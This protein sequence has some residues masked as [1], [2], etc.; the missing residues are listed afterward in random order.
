MIAEKRADSLSE[1]RAELD[2]EHAGEKCDGVNPMTQ[3]ACVK[4]YHR[5]YH[6]DEVGAEWLEEE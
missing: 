6:R 5:G 1:A 3:R 4:K 2:R